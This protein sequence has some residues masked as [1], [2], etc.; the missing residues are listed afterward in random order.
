MNQENTEVQLTPW[1]AAHP[2]IA[3]LLSDEDADDMDEVICY[4]LDEIRYA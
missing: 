3:R 1:E 4:T 2:W